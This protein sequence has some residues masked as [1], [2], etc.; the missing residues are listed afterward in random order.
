MAASRLIESFWMAG[1]D[2]GPL[3]WLLN[4]FV[5]RSPRCVRCRLIIH[6]QITHYAAHIYKVFISTRALCT[7]GTRPLTARQLHQSNDAYYVSYIS[8]WDFLNFT[9][10]I[11]SSKYH[12]EVVSSQ[13]FRLTWMMLLFTLFEIP[14]IFVD[15][16]KFYIYLVSIDYE[17][18]L[19][20]CCTT[21][22]FPF[23]SVG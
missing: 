16:L 6:R 14:G 7:E 23:A 18:N 2:G 1:R 19:I 12:G 17:C 21:F 5:V 11:C 8:G 20:L 15:F 10:V 22:L 3:C 4:D 13:F 9:S